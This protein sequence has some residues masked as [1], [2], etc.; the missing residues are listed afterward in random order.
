MAAGS[1]LSIGLAAPSAMAMVYTTGG[2]AIS[3]AM[4]NEVRAQQGMQTPIAE[5]PALARQLL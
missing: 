2:E 3:M 1:A 5:A 4:L